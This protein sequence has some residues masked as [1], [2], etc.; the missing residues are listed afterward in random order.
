MITSQG[1]RESMKSWIIRTRKGDPVYVVEAHSETSAL[2][3]AFD[4]IMRSVMSRRTR[5]DEAL[6]DLEP[7]ED[8][9]ATPE[10]RL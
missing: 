10:E 7:F 9:V 3:I 6:R 4:H 2:A 1:R 8:M 5:I